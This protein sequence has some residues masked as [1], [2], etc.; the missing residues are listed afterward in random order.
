MAHLELPQG[1][2]RGFQQQVVTRTQPVSLSSANDPKPELG[3]IEHCLV[4]AQGA[5]LRYRIDGVAPTAST[6]M[7]MPAGD[8]M[9]FNDAQ[10][11]AEAR[12]IADTATTTTLAATFFS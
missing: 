12:F 3:L 5:A 8:Y 11:I 1:L 9:A 2:S 4:Q 7:L 10:R 6:G